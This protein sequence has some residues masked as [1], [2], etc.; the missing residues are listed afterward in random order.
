M[1]DFGV[2]GVYFR[3]DNFTAS[4]NRVQNFC[5]LLLTN[6]IN[7]RWLCE[8]RVRPLSRETLT[9]MAKAGCRWLYL[10]CESGSQRVLDLIN[11]QI[12][13]QDIRNVI[14]WGKELGIKCYTSWIIGV[15]GEI[16]EDRKMTFELIKELKP[17]SAGVHVY[18]GL[19]GSTFYDEMLASGNYI[20]RDELGLLYSKDWNRL[21][22]GIS[23]YVKEDKFCP[24]QSL[25]FRIYKNI[26]KTV[27]WAAQKSPK[28][29]KLIKKIA[30]TPA[31]RSMQTDI[32][33]YL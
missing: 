18:I 7:I 8:S 33:K 22:I 9:L 23:S 20:F 17:F 27:M 29:Y 6:D 12:T 5:E 3:E 19:Q 21:A 2:Q 10:G 25:P 31:I 4:L 26:I 14:N 13:V 30:D 28:S 15:P 1:K 24:V 16:N 11:K 32:Q